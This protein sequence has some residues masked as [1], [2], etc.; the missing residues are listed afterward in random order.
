M[1]YRIE[2]IENDQ[3]GGFRCYDK[4]KQLLRS[5]EDKRYES[6]EEINN[7]LIELTDGSY[8]LDKEGYK[9]KFE[10]NLWRKADVIPNMKIDGIDEKKKITKLPIILNYLD[11]D[12]WEGDD[13]ITVGKVTID[14]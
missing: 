10:L 8:V 12:M 5:L 14:K 7:E 2:I 9:R 6:L 3:V 13:F 11:I 4:A 1:A